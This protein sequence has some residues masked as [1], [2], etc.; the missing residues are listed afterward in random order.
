MK[1]KQLLAAATLA[2]TSAATLATPVYTGN[3]DAAGYTKQ[4]GYTIWNE[5]DN[6]SQWHIRWT[7]QDANQGSNVS[8]FGSIV[9]QNSNLDGVSTFNWE[10]SDA[11]STSY[12]NWAT[13]EDSIGFRAIT[14]D[15]GDVDGIDFSLIDGTELLEFNLG[16]SLFADLESAQSGNGVEGSMI[17]LGD[18]LNTPNVFV[19]NGKN[20]I[21]QSFEVDVPE[22]GTLALLGLG[23]AGLGLARRKQAQA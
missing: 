5:D 20:G 6:A 9:F 8:W 2:L 16:S 14:N 12:D 4:T 23:L 21:Y 7:S 10:G 13:G 15:S 17:Y 22:P 11:I 3:T 19:Y 18:Q 1:L